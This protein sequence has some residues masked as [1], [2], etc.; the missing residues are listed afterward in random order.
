[1]VH[2]S[3]RAIAESTDRCLPP[4][5]LNS[6]QW[7]PSWHPTPRLSSA[8]IS[9]VKWCWTK[10]CALLLADNTSDKPDRAT[11]IAVC[12]LSSPISPSIPNIALWQRL[13]EQLAAF[14][15]LT[16]LLLS[17]SITLNLSALSLADA[18]H[19]HP[20]KDLKMELS[21]LSSS[22]RLELPPSCFGVLRE[23]ALNSLGV[24]SEFSSN[25]EL[26]RL[27]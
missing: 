2:K 22:V 18:Y 14:A 21:H 1:M 25:A 3:C 16:C 19:V 4:D 12:M 8:P 9:C 6:I 5:T 17:V 10:S 20:Y 23:F 13:M 27:V 26:P 11:T 24:C 7:I 15:K